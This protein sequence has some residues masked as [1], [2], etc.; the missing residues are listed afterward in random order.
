MYEQVIRAELYWLTLAG[1]VQ[2]PEAGDPGSIWPSSLQLYLLHRSLT[3]FH[4]SIY[5][6]MGIIVH[7]PQRGS[8]TEWDVSVTC[9]VV[10]TQSALRLSSYCHCC[11]SAGHFTSFCPQSSSRGYTLIFVFQ[12]RTLKL[13]KFDL[14][15]ERAWPLEQDLHLHFV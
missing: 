7:L 4:A 9:L 15:S 14:A 2:V 6:E 3:A 1:R 11:E 12:V 5:P 13:I 8:R 10:F